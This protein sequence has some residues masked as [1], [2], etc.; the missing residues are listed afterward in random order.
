MNK[1]NTKTNKGGRI[2]IRKLKE[3]DYTRFYELSSNPK[4]RAYHGCIQLR[5]LEE[6]LIMVRQVMKLYRMGKNIMYAITLNGE[7]I[8]AINVSRKIETTVGYWIGEQYWGHGYG[9]KALKLML[10][11]YLKHDKVVLFIFKEN[12]ASIKVALNCSFE[13]DGEIDG[14][15]KYVRQ[16]YV[17][18]KDE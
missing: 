14:V 16:Q 13:L 1:L 8:G 18:S 2:S 17:L 4:V 15:Q 7:F 6:S 3:S 11:K 9:T 10:N 12:K 5:N